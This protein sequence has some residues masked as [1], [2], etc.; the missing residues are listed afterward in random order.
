MSAQSTST[1]VTSSSVPGHKCEECSDGFYRDG[2]GSCVACGCDESG[3]TSGVCNKESGQ[4]PCVGDPS[5]YDIPRTCFSCDE[6]SYF[7]SARGVC[8]GTFLMQLSNVLKSE[9][10]RLLFTG[11]AFKSV[12]ANILNLSSTSNSS[13]FLKI[14][15][16]IIKLID[17]YL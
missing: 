5:S 2:S 1:L 4:C 7:N 16:I 3:S 12:H 14:L 15:S 10:F 13:Y 9:N 11:F 6:G 17:I 8:N